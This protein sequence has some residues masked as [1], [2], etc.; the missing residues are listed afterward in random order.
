M[1]PRPALDSSTAR[2]WALVDLAALTHNFRALEGL[3]AVPVIAVVKAAAYGHGAVAV[4]QAL[5]EAGAQMLA[6]VCVEEALELRGSGID[7][8]VLVLSESPARGEALEDELHEAI[9]A[10]VHFGAYTSDFIEVL[11]SAAERV[12]LRAAVHI[13]VDTGM[14][15][16][17]AAPQE[18][19]SLLE[20]AAARHS[21]E[22]R[23]V[24]THMAVADDPTDDFNR[25]QLERFAEFLRSARELVRTARQSRPVVVHA[26]N[27]AA[28]IAF[29]ESRFDAVRAGICLY[30]ELPS[31]DFPLPKGLGLRPVLRWE[32]TVAMVKEV[33]PG[34]RPS[35][36]R[37]RAV[38]GTRLAVIPVGYA[39]GYMRALSN[40]ADVLIRG[41]RHRIAGAVTMDH[42]IVE[43]TLEGGPEG[44]V[45]PGDRVVLIGR[46]GPE[47]ITA[48]ELAQKAGTIPYEILTRIGNRVRRVYGRDEE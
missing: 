37:T 45:R 36:G 30:G 43:C 2:S 27:S 31:S 34:S 12:G 15:R 38:Q 1:T 24:W 47:Q 4:A 39:D 33:A 44:E 17:G 13:K 11:A 46:Q 35:Y 32:S 21:L 8:P 18:A 14:H 5:S 26:A 9:R 16:L 6:V 10:G 42:I 48:T 23:G 40:V 29:P 19:L 25:V 3:V 22:V 41:R 28:A 20:K 7:T